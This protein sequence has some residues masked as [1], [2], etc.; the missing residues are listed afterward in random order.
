MK[1]KIVHVETP[2]K[3]VCRDLIDQI[4]SGTIIDQVTF[5][6]NLGPFE[7]SGINVANWYRLWLKHHN[8][9]S[10]DL[11]IPLDNNFK[12]NYKQWYEI[13]INE[14]GTVLSMSTAAKP[15]CCIIL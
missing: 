14:N 15:G 13:T 12:L 1:I 10:V 4:P 7:N 6:Q 8:I 11:F 2:P 9:F 3:N 5:S